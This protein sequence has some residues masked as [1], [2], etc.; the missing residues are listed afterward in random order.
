M[1]DKVM[2]SKCDAVEPAFID[3]VRA[4]GWPHVA[5]SL[6]DPA[7]TGRVG[8]VRDPGRRPTPD[9]DHARAAHGMAPLHDMTVKDT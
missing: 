8:F 2:G 4:Q 1:A 7:A 3:Q 5:G 6:D 9:A